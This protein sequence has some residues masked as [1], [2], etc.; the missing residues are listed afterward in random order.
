MLHS[1]EGSS[2]YSKRSFPAMDK[3]ALL[4]LMTLFIALV[5]RG[6]AVPS[7]SLP[8]YVPGEGTETASQTCCMTEQALL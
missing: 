1:N 8:W 5:H 6:Q 4:H 2:W 7:G 3:E